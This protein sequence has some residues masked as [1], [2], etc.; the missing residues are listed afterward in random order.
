MLRHG[1]LRVP[2]ELTRIRLRENADAPPPGH[3]ALIGQEGTSSTRST[4]LAIIPARA[5]Q[6]YLVGEAGGGRAAAVVGDGGGQVPQRAAHRGVGAVASTLV[7]VTAPGLP[8]GG[9]PVRGA[10]GWGPLR[11]FLLPAD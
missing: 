10:G 5:G 7:L 4:C 8:K 9:H 2:P 3:T 1:S 6:P 11:A